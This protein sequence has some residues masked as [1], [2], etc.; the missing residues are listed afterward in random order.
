MVKNWY[1]SIFESRLS[2]LR[3]LKNNC[4][5]DLVPKIDDTISIIEAL[6]SNEC[7]EQVCERDFFYKMDLEAYRFHMGRNYVEHFKYLRNKDNIY[8]PNRNVST[9]KYTWDELLE[10]TRDFFGKSLDNELYKIFKSMYKRRDK[11]LYTS[12][13]G[14]MDFLGEAI[15][16]PFYLD[17][18][19]RINKE[20]TLKNLGT[21]AHEY[22]HGIQYLTNFDMNYLRGNLMFSEVVSSF[23]QILSMDYFK[24]I[25]ELKEPFYRESIT[26]YNKKIEDAKW[27]SVLAELFNKWNNIIFEKTEK[28]ARKIVARDLN[29]FRPFLEKGDTLM[30]IDKILEAEY[31]DEIQYIVSFLIALEIFVIY[32]E[33]KK[34]GLDILKS[35]MAIDLRLSAKEYFNEITKL[36]LV[37]NAN[38]DEYDKIIKMKSSVNF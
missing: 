16:L 24:A 2:E 7:E 22:G 28:E 29:F 1:E 13:L 12:R 17:V 23:F 21:L 38:L 32:T 19:I 25:D 14:R 26:F 5:A 31:S 8:L 36:G 34:R 30:N 15:F 37:P 20:D 4:R 18:I 9:K 10:M 6:I 11:L 3:K 33:D 35:Y 27:A